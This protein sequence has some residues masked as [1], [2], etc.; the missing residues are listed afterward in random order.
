MPSLEKKKDWLN[1][2]WL[3]TK[4]GKS[5]ITTLTVKSWLFDNTKENREH[6]KKEN[7]EHNTKENREHNTKENREHNTKENREYNTK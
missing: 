7:R 3:S 6:S 2:L 1:E 4:Y 5:L